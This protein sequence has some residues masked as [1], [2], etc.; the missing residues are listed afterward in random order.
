MPQALA[1]SLTSL[2]LHHPY[3]PDPLPGISAL[4]ALQQLTVSHANVTVGVEGLARITSL[5]ALALP[6][7][8]LQVLPAAIWTL[9]QLQV[10]AWFHRCWLRDWVQALDRL[11]AASAVRPMHMAPMLSCWDNAAATAIV[12]H[13]GC[14]HHAHAKLL[15]ALPA[16]PPAN[17]SCVFGAV[18]RSAW[19]PALLQK[20]I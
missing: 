5:T 3:Q 1:P 10:R 16:R 13:R 12:G 15:L 7:C 14:S 4:T 20:Y 8:A 18:A 9:P 2:L 19:Q 6:S 11:D 17:M